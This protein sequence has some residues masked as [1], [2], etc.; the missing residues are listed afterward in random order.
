V[1]Q[2]LQKT[3]RETRG[4]VTATKW[5]S[6]TNRGLINPNPLNA[7]EKSG[8]GIDYDQSRLVCKYDG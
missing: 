3:K 4:L 8:Q 1:Q 7:M 2:L 5:T 6:L